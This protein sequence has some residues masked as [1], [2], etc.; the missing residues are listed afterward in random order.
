[1]SLLRKIVGTKFLTL[2]S[3]RS[4]DQCPESFG[5]SRS[6]NEMADTCR[7]RRLSSSSSRRHCEFLLHGDL[8][9]FCSTAGI[10]PLPHQP[11]P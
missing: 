6:R 5:L 4:V 3:S 2:E 7:L 9:S 11:K 10:S 8:W 1:M